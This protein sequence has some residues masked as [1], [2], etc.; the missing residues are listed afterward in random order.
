MT[1]FRPLINSMKIRL[2][3]RRGSI[4]APRMTIRRQLSW[5]A[6]I[7][8]MAVVL[9][10][11]TAIGVGGYLVG[12]RFAAPPV[13]TPVVQASKPDQV[14]RIS[15][16]RDR[17]ASTV[18]SADSQINM[19]RATQRQ[20]AAQVK[21]LAAE[22]SKLKDDL[23]FFESLLPVDKTSGGVSI[24]RLK[25]DIVGPNQIRYR[26]LVM[27]GG[28]TE[29]DFSGSLQLSVTVLQGGKSAIMNFPETGPE[30]VKRDP[31]ESEK[32]QLAFKRYQR[33][34]GWLTLP[35]GAE[36]K[37]MQARILEKGQLRAQQTTILE[38]ES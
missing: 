4:A 29:R 26:L 22:N 32:F 14:A 15:A 21:A 31:A 24:R 25:A 8:R 11:I 3:L 34:E 2:W 7:V 9:G 38:R 27:Q 17:Y 36:M 13:T 33:I 35:N 12:R 16:E 6:K 37:S 10:G 20:L 28:K 19:E 18:H 1:A 5:P 30:A 23:A